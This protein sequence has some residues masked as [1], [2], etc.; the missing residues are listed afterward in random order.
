M[1]LDQAELA[2]HFVEE[3]FAMLPEVWA[4]R[5]NEIAQT[6]TNGLFPALQINQ[7][8]VD[9]TNA[10]LKS[11]EIPFGCKRLVGEGRDGL[12]RAINA[13]AADS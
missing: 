13:Q 9:R 6:L 7:Q 12:V 8:M 3:Y 1:P 11:A 4:N 5:S 10:F 2:S